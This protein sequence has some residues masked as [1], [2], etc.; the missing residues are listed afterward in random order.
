MILAL[1][2]RGE[3]TASL[4]NVDIWVK[5][6]PQKYKC[7]TI[8]TKSSPFSEGKGWQVYIKPESKSFD[9]SKI[10]LNDK[11]L[12]KYADTSKGWVKYTVTDWDKFADMLGLSFGDDTGD[13]E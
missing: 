4:K 3:E 2:K 11:C 13:D 5:L 9:G 7:A 10:K 12:K 6:Y 8:F 1:V